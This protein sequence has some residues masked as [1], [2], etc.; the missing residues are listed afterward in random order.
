VR[1][2]SVTKSIVQKQRCFQPEFDV[3]RHSRIP[4]HNAILKWVNN[5]NVCDSVVKKFVG[6]ARSVCTPEDIGTVKAAMQQSPTCSARKHMIALHMSSSSLRRILHED[7]RFHPYKIQ[8]HHELKEQ[9]KAS[10]LNFC[11]EF[12]DIVN[13]YDGIFGCFDHVR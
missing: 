6:P 9:D 5:F 10:H 8:V 1:T 2:Y 7:L 13:N 4:L 3:S 12:L 11:R